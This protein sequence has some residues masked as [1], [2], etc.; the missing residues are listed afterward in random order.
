M[1]IYTL[2]GSA[3][4]DKKIEAD[5]EQIK[6]CVSPHCKAGILL[7]SYGRGEGTPFMLPDGTQAP[8]NDYDLV[9]I[10]D[11]A[12]AAV[13]SHVRKL[14]KKLTEQI[15]LPVDLYPYAYESLPRCEFSLL[16]YEMKH[17]HRVLW[18]PETILD[19]M[20]DYDPESIPL[21][22]GT[23]L[24]L[25]RGKLL[26]D[27]QNRLKNPEPLSREEH[28]QYLKFLIKVLLAFGDSILLFSGR[29]ELSYAEKKEQIGRVGTFPASDYII[30]G[31]RK[32]VKL[33]ESGDFLAWNTFNV[34]KEFKTVREVYLHYMP[35]YRARC[36]DSNSPSLKNLLLNLKWNRSLSASHP[37]EKLYTAILALLEG[38]ESVMP[39]EQFNKVWRRFS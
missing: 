22:E 37:R 36:I 39:M 17:G 26:L 9:V 25:N 2:R 7:G 30:D 29:Y 28:T 15:G 14:E 1:P 31:Y 10:T 18:G 27:L 8:F 32:A 12:N 19:R 24:L 21:S 3:E 38:D 11:S 33:K 23:R 35:W 20:P 4:L 16:N 34:A 13:K 6:K 5:L